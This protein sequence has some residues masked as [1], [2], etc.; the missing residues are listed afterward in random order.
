LRQYSE[1]LDIPGQ[2]RIG[3]VL[4][5]HL[6]DLGVEECIFLAE[7]SW[8]DL[9]GLP[10]TTEI[11]QEGLDTDACIKV[12]DLGIALHLSEPEPLWLLLTDKYSSQK[13][14]P[15]HAEKWRSKIIKT[16]H[17]NDADFFSALTEYFSRSL[18]EELFCEGCSQNGAPLYVE[19]RIKRLVQLLH[20]ILLKDES[21]LEICC[22][23]GMATQALVRLGQRPISMDSDRCDLCQGLKSELLDPK[24]CFVLDARLL[25]CLF[26][27]RSVHTVL[28]FMVGL[29]DDFNWPLW[30]DILLKASSLAKKR[31]LFTVYTQKEAELIAKALG[32][33]GW[34]GRVIDNRDSKGIYDQWAYLAVMEE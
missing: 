8:Q 22:G 25:P 7:E 33:A 21:M 32:D 28:G 15:E 13:I 30:R 10:V 29:I 2:Y 3:F 31:V 27:A 6:L 5:N 19:E 1:K 34:N 20:P 16:V 17:A 11:L 26:P 12:K 24:R 9:L 23:S 14:L 4:L 18:A